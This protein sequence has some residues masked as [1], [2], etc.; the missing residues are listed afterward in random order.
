MLLRNHTKPE[1][2]VFVFNGGGEV[3]CFRAAKP[4]RKEERRFRASVAQ[5]RWICQSAYVGKESFYQVSPAV[6]LD[7][8]LL[9]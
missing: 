5:P 8:G 1:A 3:A 7:T 4:D 6:G 2:F 9:T